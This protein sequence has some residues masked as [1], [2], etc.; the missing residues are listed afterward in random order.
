MYGTACRWII[1]LMVIKVCLYRS[2]ES[3]APLDITF[4]SPSP[5]SSNVRG[6]AL[7]NSKTTDLSI[8]ILNKNNK[9]NVTWADTGHLG[10]EN[11]KEKTTDMPGNKIFGTGSDIVYRI[12]NTFV[13]LGVANLPISERVGVFSFEAS[14]SAV[15]SRSA[16]VVTS[17]LAKIRMQF[18]TMTVGIG[19]S[20][21]INL[22]EGS[23]YNDLRWRH[24]YGDV[25]QMWTGNSSV[26]I[27]NIRAKDDGVY[28]CY[29]GDSP[30]NNHGVMRLI[31]R[32]CPLSKWSPPECEIDCPVCYNGGVCDDKTG[33]CICP[34]GFKGENCETGCGSNNWGRNCDVVCSSGVNKDEACRGQLF[35]PPD[36]V[37]CACING[38]TGTKCDTACDSSHYGAGCRQVCH[39]HSGEC[40]RKTGSCRPTSKCSVGYTG[41]ACQ[42]L[43]PDQ[44]CPSGFFG[45]LCNYP[46][47]CKDSADCNRDG[48]CDNGCHKAWA[49]ADCSIALPYS[50]KPPALLNQTATTLMIS[51]CS[52][53]PVK[54]FG[55]GNIS[56]CNLWYRTSQK[57]TFTTID[58]TENG[59]YTIDNL[60]PHTT[61]ELYTQHSRLIGGEVTDGPPSEHG[62][63][64]TICTKPLEKPEIELKAVERNE[65]ILQ[66]LPVSHAPERI[67]C[68]YILRYQVRYRSEDGNEHGIVNTTDSS[69]TEVKILGL[70]ECVAYVV[71]SRVINN[72]E[73]IGA[74]GE[75]VHVQIAPSAPSIIN[76]SVK[77]KTYLLMKWNAST[78]NNQDQIMYHYE[79]SGGILR[80]GNTTQTEVLINDGIVP[81]SQYTF[82]VF[83]SHLGMNGAS[84][85]ESLFS[86]VDYPG[87][88]NITSLTSTSSSITLEWTTPE[89]NPCKILEYN[90]LVYSDFVNLTMNAK[91]TSLSIT[92]DILPNTDYSVKVAA[93]TK[94]GYGDFSD[95][96]NV[97]TNNDNSKIGAVIGAL[98]GGLCVAIFGIVAFIYFERR[99]NSNRGVVK[100]PDI[101][102]EIPVVH[103]IETKIMPTV[104]G[105]AISV[106]AKC[107]DDDIDFD[108]PIEN[109]YAN[110]EPIYGNTN[111]E[112][113]K[114]KPIELEK[115][116]DYIL[117]RNMSLEN[118]FEKEFEDLGN[119]PLYP[120]TAAKNSKNKTK[121][122]YAN[123]IPYDNSRVVLGLWNNIPESDYINASYIDGYT[124]P[125]EFIAC[126]GP[127]VASVNDMWRM[128]WQKKSTIIVVVTNV[129]EGTRRK[130]E[131]Y[132]PD[133]ND[134]NLYTNIA[135]TN[136]GETKYGNYVVRNLQLQKVGMEEVHS[137]VQYHFTDW[138]DKSV[139]RAVPHL[140]DFI[141]AFRTAQ[142]NSPSDS[143]PVIVHCSAGAGRTGTVIVIASML[144]MAKQEGKVDVFNFVRSIREKRIQMVQT[145]EQYKFIYAALLEELF[146]GQTQIPVT[147]LNQVILDQQQV[148][149][150]PSTIEYQLKTLNSIYPRPTDDRTSHARLPD[151]ILK[152]RSKDVLPLN[153]ARPFL[154]TPCVNGNDYINASFCDGYNKRN[155]FIVAQAPMSEPADTTVDFWRLVLDYKTDI[156]VQL[157]NK[158]ETCSEFLPQRMNEEL[159]IDTF[160]IIIKSSELNDLMIERKLML[161]KDNKTQE[162]LHFEF[163]Q[164]SKAEPVPKV[165]SFIRFIAAVQR[166]HIPQS[167]R[168]I[169]IHCLDGTVRSGLFCSVYSIID[170]IKEEKIVDVFQIL[171][172][173]R[174]TCPTMV[175][176]KVQY[177][178]CY[179]AARCYLEGFEVY[180]NV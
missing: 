175:N 32:D 167:N 4:F 84:D 34:A 71:D 86:D 40:D 22:S 162:I 17:S 31:V 37:G 53:D 128:I 177:S 56:G 42:E 137:V 36:P 72:E 43:M 19:E 66:L 63:A 88:P 21:T 163:R 144:D 35:C 98:A 158:D 11:T 154:M 114:Y 15:V 6:Y 44:A 85:N 57:S 132:W 156:I 92:E 8:G 179:E 83:A 136:V 51:A 101:Q 77:E 93:K 76:D 50:S 81:C 89:A 113:Q 79:L 45:V 180:V 103:D 118:G 82:T 94:R 161:K 116:H 28:E 141:Y 174:S 27:E 148:Y 138:P 33:L 131:Q 124:T 112:I 153:K 170:K 110:A 25:I 165:E 59:V 95:T 48:S 67:Q 65:I 168:P 49:G 119:K 126:Q 12:H 80:K 160:T 146:C 169:I 133:P 13:F 107:L 130:C 58:N 9:D 14:K 102:Q 125:H 60:L 164:W 150:P 54:D 105:D 100:S 122:R 62:L 115:L 61:V 117:K 121:N 69:Q 46:C 129:V 123:V 91:Q 171:K 78:C 106:E 47:H 104:E 52:W 2:T 23:G 178:F 75:Y 139:P 24:N 135:V 140:I 99:S 18:R 151:N 159:R 68:D 157:N 109:V 55:T 87:K 172:T 7:Q 173:L 176:T 155:A 29:R 39:C 10:S 134:S 108:P 96:E 41:P 166:G 145:E 64:E 97:S 90:V 1:I 38:Y 3:A 111:L 30:D 152:N 127:T 5:H 120:W 142:R 147:D 26:T 16:I 74:W 149:G 70:S 20:V 143:G 73:F